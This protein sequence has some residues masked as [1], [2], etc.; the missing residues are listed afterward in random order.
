MQRRTQRRVQS[1]TD[2]EPTAELDAYEADVPNQND[3]VH[4]ALA[5][6]SPEPSDWPDRVL[7]VAVAPISLVLEVTEIPEGRMRG[8]L[9]RLRSVL[10]RS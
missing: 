7:N 6:I 2:F 1:R 10:A 9:V 8:D 3:K 4:A 5:T